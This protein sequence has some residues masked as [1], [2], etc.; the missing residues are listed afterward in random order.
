M[1][2]LPNAVDTSSIADRQHLPVTQ[3]EP[4]EAP[5]A[6]VTVEHLPLPPI[7]EQNVDIS[8]SRAA[9]APLE[10]KSCGVA[11]DDMPNKD[12]DPKVRLELETECLDAIIGF[13]C[14][15]WL[16]SPSETTW[17]LLRQNGLC[18]DTFASFAASRSRVAKALV[19]CWDVIEE[20]LSAPTALEQKRLALK[21]H[22]IWQENPLF[23][24]S[25]T[26]IPVGSLRNLNFN[27]DPILKQLPQTQNRCVRVLSINVLPAFIRADSGRE[28]VSNLLGHPKE[29]SGKPAQHGNNDVLETIQNDDNADYC[30]E[31]A[32][33][34]L[35]SIPE[36]DPDLYT[37]AHHPQAGI[38]I[39]SINGDCTNKAAFWLE[40]VTNLIGDNDVSAPR[41][42]DRLQNLNGVVVDA[43][44]MS[45]VLSPE[46]S[47]WISSLTGTFGESIVAEVQLALEA[48]PAHSPRS[49]H[50]ADGRLILFIQP[51]FSEDDTDAHKDPTYRIVF[52]LEQSNDLKQ[53]KAFDAAARFLQYTPRTLSGRKSKADREEDIACL[54]TLLF[55]RED[56]RE[57]TTTNAVRT[58]LVGLPSPEPLLSPKPVLLSSPKKER[59]STAP[60]SRSVLSYMMSSWNM[61]DGPDGASELCSWTS[62]PSEPLQGLKSSAARS[63]VMT[64]NRK[65]DTYVQRR[66]QEHADAL[67]NGEFMCD[68]DE[69]QSQHF[70]ARSSSQLSTAQNLRNLI[71]ERT[72]LWRDGLMEKAL[73]LDEP[74]AQLQAQHL[75]ERMSRLTRVLTN[76]KSKLEQQHYMR[77]RALMARHKQE[78]MTLDKQI[79]EGLERLHEQHQK[80]TEDY[81]TE[82]MTKTGAEVE[83]ED[84]E[85]AD[86][87]PYLKKQQRYSLRTTTK[88]PEMV[89][90][91]SYFRFS[92]SLPGP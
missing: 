21:Y 18:H 39:L 58:S 15:K 30:Q 46:T 41:N 68:D 82:V 53:L 38:P 89:R 32:T 66:R 11:W 2:H 65:L 4:R 60:A 52:S 50:I 22:A 24:F 23:L 81:I 78:C 40:M 12:V 84:D 16:Q 92:L 71:Q 80:Q 48:T 45:R 27:W 43:R 75:K 25:Q 47:S 31:D 88:S 74:I 87:K 3:R 35:P 36:V 90:V 83:N 56:A 28:L 72:A 91:A 76:A 63:L 70:D 8:V 20:I 79:Q 9:C 19:R 6:L 62:R 17:A 61:N 29:P 51:Y 55:F 26:E 5:E 13:T 49:A 37:A 42:K 33:G 34:K 67:N 85:V 1:A 64:I 14:V 59:P 69:R 7:V 54:K 10:S 73:E 57:E 77:L 86:V 44:D